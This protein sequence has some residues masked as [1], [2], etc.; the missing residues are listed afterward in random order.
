MPKHEE[1]IYKNVF[2]GIKCAFVGVIN[3][4][5]ITLYCNYKY[6]TRQAMYV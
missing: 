1:A 4:Y 3:E 2:I 6:K 5:L